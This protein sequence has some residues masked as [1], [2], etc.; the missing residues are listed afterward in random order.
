MYLTIHWLIDVIF[1][2]ILSLLVIFI[3][4]KTISDD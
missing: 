1:G 2:V 3:I 4:D